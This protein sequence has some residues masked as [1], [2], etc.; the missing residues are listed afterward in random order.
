MDTNGSKDPVAPDTY[1][2]L[3]GFLPGSDK[4]TGK[5]DEIGR[6]ERGKEG[7]LSGVEWMRL[8]YP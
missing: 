6:S 8:G 2:L 5:E 4:R 7:A 1:S 3:V